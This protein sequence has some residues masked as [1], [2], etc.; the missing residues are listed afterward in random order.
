MPPKRRPGAQGTSDRGPSQQ[1]ATSAYKTRSVTGSTR[2][3]RTTTSGKRTSP[4]DAPP[5]KR[6]RQ[7]T[8]TSQ[9]GL[10]ES[11]VSR[12]AEAVLR[13]VRQLSTRQDT[14]NN[15]AATENL[16]EDESS[17]TDLSGKRAT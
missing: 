14:A 13:Q 7:S 1:N 9:P 3:R 5:V 15:P 6:T 8:D 2:G 16:Y 4:S 10:T 11:E 17:E 12:I